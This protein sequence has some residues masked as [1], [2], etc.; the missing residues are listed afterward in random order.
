MQKKWKHAIVVGASQGIGE[1]LVLELA[2]GGVSVGLVSRNPDAMKQVISKAESLAASA[3][4]KPQTPNPTFI[5]FVHDVTNYAEAP[6]LFQEITRQL[7]GLD[8]II[9][10]AGI[11]PE[12]KLDEF[13]FAKDKSIIDVNVLGAMSWLNEAAK[14]FRAAG[15]GTIAGISSIAG[16]RGRRGMPAYIASKSALSAYLESLRNRLSQHGVKVVTIKPGVIDTEMA[17]NSPLK[18]WIYSPEKAAHEIIRAAR[19]GTTVKYVPW[20]WRLVSFVLH[21]TPSFIFRR[22]PI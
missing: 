6:A 16:E 5:S 19:R 8:L 13:D 9:Y 14:R 18:L 3:N 20:K 15:S 11:M 10:N 12:V 4:P 17:K 21:T 1:A 7:G 2:R 22:L